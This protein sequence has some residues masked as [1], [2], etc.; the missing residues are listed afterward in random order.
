VLPFKSC[1]LEAAVLAGAPVAVARIRYWIENGSAADDVCYWGD[2]VLVPHLLKLFRIE[3][4]EA[5]VSFGLVESPAGDRK[6]LSK[7]LY[8][9]VSALD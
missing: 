4:I 2:M 3:K 6:S 7:Q 8:A 5:H 9:Q 1:L